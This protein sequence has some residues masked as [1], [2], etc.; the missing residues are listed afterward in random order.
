MGVDLYIDGS[1]VCGRFL[2]IP[3]TYLPTV[4]E[5]KYADQFLTRTSDVRFSLF[6][7]M[8]AMGGTDRFLAFCK[9]LP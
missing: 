6:T 2:C 3:Y 7:Q 5:A 9:T 1:C 8:T 4:H